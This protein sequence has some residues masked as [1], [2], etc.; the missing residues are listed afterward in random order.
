VL[1]SSASRKLPFRSTSPVHAAQLVIQGARPKLPL[2]CPVHLEALIKR[3]WKADPAVRPSFDEI[4]R[5]LSAVDL[6]AT[7]EP[8][9]HPRE[10]T[11]VEVDSV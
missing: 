7:A 2:D 11:S 8:S 9:D 10:S 1:L 4:I 6:Q 3:C 5:I